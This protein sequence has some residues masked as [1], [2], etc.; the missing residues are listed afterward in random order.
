[1]KKI[2]G[3]QLV[4]GDKETSYKYWEKCSGCPEGHPS[5]WKTIVE[6]PQWKEWYKE[7]SR[8]MH[9]EP[10]G[11]CFDVDEC[12]ECG[13]FSQHHFQEFMDF[14]TFQTREHTPMGISQWLNHGIKYEYAKF[15]SEKEREKVLA[16]VREKIKKMSDG[17]KMY[18]NK[19]QAGYELALDDVLNILV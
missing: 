18:R 7:N 1:M 5:F 8:R 6:S 11:Q 16:E 12:Q 4:F 2:L 19:F 15:W 3:R 13:W 10:I 9:L 14:T 17:G